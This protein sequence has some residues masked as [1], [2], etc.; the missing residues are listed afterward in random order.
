MSSLCCTCCSRG[1][2]PKSRGEVIRFDI[3]STMSKTKASFLLL[4]SICGVLSAQEWPAY[5][6]DPGGSKYSRLSQINREN[7]SRLK[8]AWT[9]HTG[10]MSD[11]SV[12]PPR[13]AFEGT[14]LVIDGVM[15]VTTPFSRL[16]A[17]D[18]ETGKQIWAFDPKIDKERS[19]N[20]FIS[21]G[22]AWWSSGGKKIGRA[23]CR[24]EGW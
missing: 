9:F 12:Y 22:S 3:R 4:L 15:Y 1:A 20:L 11:G 19:A 24:E 23:S 21:R 13:S 16:I 5:A 14:P 18:A 6:G 10:D 8:V 2:A 17:L 7:V